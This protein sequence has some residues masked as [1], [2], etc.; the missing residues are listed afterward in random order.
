MLGRMTNDPRRVGQNPVNLTSD[1]ITF[2]TRVRWASNG[3][4]S[5]N[6]GG[7]GKNCLFI[8]HEHCN[9][10]EL[11]ISAIYLLFSDHRKCFN[12]ILID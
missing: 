4:K 2:R 1:A 12:T 6:R 9:M 3:G 10:A 5:D 7:T 11:S 8:D